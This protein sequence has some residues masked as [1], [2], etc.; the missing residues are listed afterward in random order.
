MIIYNPIKDSFVSQGFSENKACVRT[1]SQGNAFRPFQVIGIRGGV[2]PVNSIP[3]YPAIGMKGHSGR[4]EATYF[5]SPCFFPVIAECEGTAR[6]ANDFDGGIVLDIYSKSRIH[7]DKLPKEAGEQAKA[8]WKS[9]DKQMYVK[10]RF[11]H[12]QSNV[13]RDNT[14]VKTQDL[15]SLCD[16]TGASSGNHLHWS[17][18]FVD[19]NRVTLDTNNGHYVAVDFAQWYTDMFILD[20]FLKQP[21]LTTEQILYKLAW[22]IR[23]IDRQMAEILRAVAKIVVAFGSQVGSILSDV[24]KK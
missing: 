6:E 14:E 22:Q 16:N 7:I 13:V 8:E 17:M 3:F 18:K 19:G 21:K 24:K 15:I 4:D 10:F 11:W 1:D 5:K 23:H 12:N 9:H 20:L 2:C